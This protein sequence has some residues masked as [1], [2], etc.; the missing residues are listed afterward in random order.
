[1]LKPDSLLWSLQLFC[2]MLS[3]LIA[4]SY[5]ALPDG[6]FIKC[7][8]NLSYKTS[9]EVN[10]KYPE[11]ESKEGKKKSNVMKFYSFFFLPFF[12]FKW[13]LGKGVIYFRVRYHY[14]SMHSCSLYYFYYHLSI[15]SISSY[16]LLHSLYFLF[17]TIDHSNMFI[18]ITLCVFL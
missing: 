5:Q 3:I 12:F 11:L 15:S 14:C 8:I 1:M 4:K 16:P 10:P 18:G 9:V 17:P 7:V 2:L 6:P 13:T